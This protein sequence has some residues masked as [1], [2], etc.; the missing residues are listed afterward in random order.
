[1]AYG[2]RGNKKLDPTRCVKRF[3]VDYSSRQCSRKRVVGDY[4]RQHDPVARQE[5]DKVRRAKW[6]HE[7]AVRGALRDVQEARDAVVECAEAWYD[8][9]NEQALAEAIKQLNLRRAEHR[10][11]EKKA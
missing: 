9:G 8:T 5:K 6:Q 11:L 10:A 3:M 2:S 4:C 1:M 7:S